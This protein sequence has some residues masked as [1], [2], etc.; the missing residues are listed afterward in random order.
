MWCE[1]KI[2]ASTADDCQDGGKCKKISE[3]NQWD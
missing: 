1:I 3:A 2:A